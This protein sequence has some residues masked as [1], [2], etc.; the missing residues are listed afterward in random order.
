MN[1]YSTKIKQKFMLAWAIKQTCDELNYK[2][3]D[4]IVYHKIIVMKQTSYL[5]VSFS[6]LSKA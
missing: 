4:D 5:L 2:K 3:Y 1:L 6:L